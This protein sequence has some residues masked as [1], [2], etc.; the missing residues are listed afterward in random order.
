MELVDIERLLIKK[1]R[2]YL[3]SPFIKAIK[4]FELINEN[5]KIA[6][7]ISG[8]KDSLLCAKLIQELHRHSDIKFDVEYICMDPGYAKE[9]RKN[10][11]ENLKYLNIK[12]NIYDSNVFA[13]SEK[14]SGNYPCYMCARM[15]RGF[16]Y[17]KA[18][19]LGCNKV[20]LGHHLNDAIE[21][22][23]MNVLFSGNFKTMKPKLK[24]QNFQ[25]MELIRPLYYIDE[26]MIKKWRDEIGLNALNCACAVTKKS[27]GYTRKYVKELIA[28]LEKDIPNVRKSILRSAE[29][30]NCDMVLAY[31]I[32]GKKHS[33]LEEF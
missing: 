33:F 4:D 32:K 9:H 30:V 21:T 3:W 17:A 19:E 1:Y 26:E 5:D 8:G 16:L 11:E 23:L 2:K 10:L 7:A 14:I 12:A 13:V 20:A 31:Q 15:R 24:A 18:K 6:V 28:N 29:N 27:E 22:T 25:G